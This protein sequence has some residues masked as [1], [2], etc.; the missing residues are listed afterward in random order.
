MCGLTYPPGPFS[1][2][3]LQSNPVGLVFALWLIG[4]VTVGAVW[5]DRAGLRHIEAVAERRADRRRLWVSHA[6][7][8]G[9]VALFWHALTY[10]HALDLWN[11]RSVLVLNIADK[12]NSD[13]V[14]RWLQRLRIQYG[15]RRGSRLPDGNNRISGCAGFRCYLLT[16]RRIS[17]AAGRPPRAARAC[18]YQPDMIVELLRPTVDAPLASRH[19]R[20]VR[21]A[22]TLAHRPARR[23]PLACALWHALY[24]S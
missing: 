15:I 11:L 1:L 12:T 7:I 13:C 3:V 6:V 24:W 16:H 5:I 2:N 10:N 9:F 20:P 23:L 17:P 4:I 19:A 8:I 22:R 21:T 18:G 14:L